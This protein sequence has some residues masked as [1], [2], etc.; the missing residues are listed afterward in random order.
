M[1]NLEDNADVVAAL[2]ALAIEDQENESQGYVIV[3][4]GD[5]NEG[6]LTYSKIDTEDENTYPVTIIIDPKDRSGTTILVNKKEELINFIQNLRRAV[7]ESKNRDSVHLISRDDIFDYYVD[8][9]DAIWKNDLI[10]RVRRGLTHLQYQ[11]L[12]NEKE[13]FNWW[14]YWSAC[15]YYGK[16]PM[17]ISSDEEKGNFGDARLMS[18]TR[19]MQIFRAMASKGV[20]EKGT[21]DVWNADREN[22]N[23]LVSCLQRLSEQVQRIGFSRGKTDIALDDDKIRN[24]SKVSTERL[25]LQRTFQRGGVSGPS[26]ISA[27]SKHTGLLMSANYV[28]RNENQMENVKSVA[29]C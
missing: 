6:P 15:H 25:S 1:A 18:R 8:S 10:L 20:F 27:V 24:R 7:N 19:F 26:L 12:E 11:P 22:A 13:L 3:D 29:A 21:D 4:S 14:E 23:L 16:S 17:T 2:Q 28:F 5:F 9:T